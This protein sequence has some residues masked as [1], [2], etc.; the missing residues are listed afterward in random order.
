[1]KRV[2]HEAYSLQKIPTFDF[3]IYYSNIK[4]KIYHST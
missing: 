2:K 3:K 4:S 1:M